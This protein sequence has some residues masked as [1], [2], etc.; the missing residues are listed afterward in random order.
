[1]A[2]FLTVPDLPWLTRVFLLGQRA[3]PRGYA[4]LFRRPWL[5]WTAFVL[6]TLIVLTY[7]AFTFHQNYE[8]SKLSGRQA[9]LPPLFGL[10]EV[11]EF[12]LDG[13]GRPPLTIDGDRWQRMTVNK[14]FSFDRK[15]PGR[16]RV[17]VTNMQGKPVLNAEMTVDEEAKTLTLTPPTN[18]FGPPPEG[19]LPAG[20]VLKYT[21][22]EPGVIEVDGKV[23]YGTKGL[24]SP[25]GP[26]AVKARLRMYGPDRFLLSSRGFHWINEMPYNQYGPR[27]D[28][29]PEIA[30]PPKRP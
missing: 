21:E 10:W 17:Q 6:R 19:K 11:E 18:P 9:P 24:T 15:S 29:P 13:T 1:M 3:T 20:Q 14:G 26:R 16:P 30:P 5:D 12:S 25:A 4:P 2:L 8:R 23:T 27:F 7:L 22:P 28:P